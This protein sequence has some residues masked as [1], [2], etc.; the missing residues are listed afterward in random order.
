MLTVPAAA[1]AAPEFRFG[2]TAGEVKSSSA[3]VWAS[4]TE[5]A[6]L[7]AQVATDS[8]FANIVAEKPVAATLEHDFTAQTKVSGLKAGKR[9]RYR[10]CVEGTD[11]CSDVGRFQTAPKPG[12]AATVRFAYTGDTDA[13]TAMGQSDP[14]FGPFDVFDSMLA[15]GNAFNIHIGDTIYSD[16][17]VPGL[18]P[19]L[20]LEEKWD[21]YKLNLGQA[22]LVALRGATGFYS[23]WDDHEFIND[24]SIPENGQDL[25][26]AGVA[27]FRDYAP[28]GYTPEDGL[29]R[30]FRWGKNLE[31]FFL[32]ERS[33]RSAKASANGV[34]DNS[35]TDAPD[36]APTAPQPIRNVFSQLIPSLANP[37]SQDCK[38]E[39]NDPQRTLLGK[40][41]LK[42][43]LADLKGSK[44]TWK[45]I[46][47][48]TPI[49]QFYGLPYDRWEG[50]AYER[51]KL[52]E[53]L[54][55]KHIKHVVFLTTD[56][57][58]DFAN[59]IRLRTLPNDV[60]PTN[61]PSGPKDTPYRDFITG[62]VAT[63]T[64]W[65]EIDGVTGTE[66][67][68]ELLSTQFFKP[69]LGMFCAQGDQDSYAEVTASS[70]KLKVAYKASDGGPV[71]DVDDTKCG[72]YTLK[73]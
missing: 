34:C 69:V 8:G 56:T 20:T 29:Y 43:F 27:A 53:A 7:D 2:V 28:V 12:D 4:V 58:A 21:K 3:K 23:Q 47:N 16:S 49:Q 10:F 63:G 15:E 42:E 67:S 45:V 26:D 33:F 22:P 71:T 39:I 5:A 37:V 41:Q 73:R 32:D 70:K 1:A 60:A 55:K 54:Q 46:M 68:G 11:T 72:P 18:P 38:D 51:V 17:E 25:Y 62:P 65:R 64:F 50:Y 35:D 30:T 44:A 61:A 40:P 52:L 36:L 31:L 57:H 66:G 19:A 9:Y 59:V 48:E 14:F 24:F 6:A 13:A